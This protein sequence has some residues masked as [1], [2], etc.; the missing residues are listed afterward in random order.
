VLAVITLRQRAS[1]VAIVRDQVDEVGSGVLIVA[2]M[3]T[4]WEIRAKGTLWIKIGS[5]SPHR[6]GK[7]IV[8][9]RGKL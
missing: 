2:W 7:A 1:C 4:M 6:F 5:V 3:R 8:C 9:L